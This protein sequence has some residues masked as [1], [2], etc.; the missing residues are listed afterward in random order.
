MK[1][2]IFIVFGLIVSFHVNADEKQDQVLKKF[3]GI[4]STPLQ[5][6]LGKTN[7]TEKSY[8]EIKASDDLV[9]IQH[10]LRLIKDGAGGFVLSRDGTGEFT[11]IKSL[12]NVMS[13]TGSGNEYFVT[14]SNT[15]PVYI[16]YFNR[17]SFQID[18]YKIHGTTLRLW[19]RKNEVKDEKGGDVVV[20]SVEEGYVIARETR[21]FMRSYES[22]IYVRCDD[23]NNSKIIN[24]AGAEYNKRGADQTS[25]RNYS[26]SRSGGKNDSTYAVGKRIANGSKIKYELKKIADELSRT[27]SYVAETIVRRDNSSV[28][29]QIRCQDSDE[30]SIFQRLG[31]LN[32]YLEFSGATIPVETVDTFN[33]VGNRY[34]QKPFYAFRLNEKMINYSDV[35]Y[36]SERFYNVFLGKIG[37]IEDGILYPNGYEYEI[38]TKY[39]GR[40]GYDSNGVKRARQKYPPLYDVAFK[41]SS[42]KGDFYIEVPPYDPAIQYVIASCKS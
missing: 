36:Q 18:T 7:K 25:A 41:M 1:N 32:I 39:F 31:K 42:S 35:F 38:Q 22:T 14:V 34:Q 40:V 37:S 27:E 15:A 2:I 19:D 9:E 23:V 30:N 4:W 12:V 21:D 33:V 11:I 8:I 20:T 16:K 28:L 17:T 26:G 24:E 3:Y 29:V 6:Y 10:K 5:C 13:V